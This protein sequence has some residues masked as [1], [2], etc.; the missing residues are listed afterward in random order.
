M[1]KYAEIL[2]HEP[3]AA[4]VALIDKINAYIERT[5]AEHPEIP[6]DVLW[7]DLKHDLEAA[8]NRAE[9]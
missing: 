8:I 1:S 2:G 7:T 4:T 9:G 6:I 3:T 5:H